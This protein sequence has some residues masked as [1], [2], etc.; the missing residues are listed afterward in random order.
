MDPTQVVKRI[1]FVFLRPNVD[2]SGVYPSIIA[3]FRRFYG[4]SISA[5]LSGIL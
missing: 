5:Q 4:M 2:V 1:M 3:K